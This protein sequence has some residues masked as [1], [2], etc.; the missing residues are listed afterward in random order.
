MK[1]PTRPTNRDD[2]IDSRDVIERAKWLESELDERYEEWLSGD[3]KRS[4]DAWPMN[5]WLEMMRRDG[6]DEAIEHAKLIELAEQAEGSPDWRY[7][8][9]LIR[10]SYFKEHAMELAHDVGDVTQDQLSRW[11]F[12]CIDWDEAAKEL[13]MDYFSVDFDGIDYWIRS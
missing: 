12:T 6:D 2:I 9:I 10:D 11:P 8:E 7:G 1:E 4:R 13:K 5:A 3:E